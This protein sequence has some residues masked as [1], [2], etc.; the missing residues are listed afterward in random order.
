[1]THI[2]DFAAMIVAGAVTL[3]E[4]VVAEHIRCLGDERGKLLTSM[5]L[6]DRAV[7]LDDDLKKA[8][9]RVGLSHL[10]AASGLNLTI[11]V[12]ACVFFFGLTRRGKQPGP[13]GLVQTLGSLVCVLFFVSL[14]G[15][16]PSVTRATIMCLLL[17]WSSL[18][19]RRL[20]RGAALAGA[21]WLAVFFDP[22]SILDVGLELSY[23]ATFG[24]IYL[25]P[26]FTEALPAGLS[27]KPWQWLCSICAVVMAAQLAVLPVQIFYFQKVSTLV[28]PAN[29]LAEPLVA[30]ITVLGFISS[31]ISALAFALTSSSSAFNP[32]CVLL[33][34]SLLAQ[35]F[36]Q[37]SFAIDF[38]SGYL[39]DLLLWLTR[40]LGALPFSY[41][42]LA[43]PAAISIVFYYLA[44][45]VSFLVG[46]DK[47]A[48]GAVLALASGVALTGHSFL[49]SPCLEVFVAG[50]KVLIGRPLDPPLLLNIEAYGGPCERGDKGYLPAYHRDFV[51]SYLRSLNGKPCCSVALPLTQICRIECRPDGLLEATINDREK[52]AS[53][54][55]KF[56]VV[57][58]EN[59]VPV[60]VSPFPGLA[61]KVEEAQGIRFYRFQLWGLVWLML[62]YG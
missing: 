17:L 62:G 13:A 19:F 8:F 7:S 45:F 31:L 15:A 50:Q 39:I 38:L 11:I 21:L 57:Q 24:I 29:I 61:T 36:S 54:Y 5:V 37:I 22:L 60:L 52:S 20:A 2:E 3:R 4:G 14:A 16:S 56:V 47:P 58:V 53:N 42:Y 55:K 35:L 49:M 6:G 10:L 44:L 46:L 40:S 30:P 48:R 41:L 25:Y 26:I 12:G 33:P 34:L 18:L 9:N 23:G 28:L 32:C 51:Q 43:P 59:G 1:L 27:R